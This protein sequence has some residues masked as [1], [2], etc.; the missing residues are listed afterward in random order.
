MVQS[1]EW[2]ER[3]LNYESSTLVRKKFEEF[4]GR[5]LNAGKAQEIAASFAQ[6]RNY[7]TVAQ[8]ADRTVRPLLVYYGVL[9]FSRAIILFRST[10]LRESGLAASHGLSIEGWGHE[11]SRDDAKFEDLAV[12]VGHS[13]TFRELAEATNNISFLRANSSKPNWRLEGDQIPPD[14]KVTI[15]EVASRIP[16]VAA[17][18]TRWLGP[19]R[20]LKFDHSQTTDKRAAL[21]VGPNVSMADVKEIFGE[22]FQLYEELHGYLYVNADPLGF[23]GAISDAV[24][25]MQVGDVVVMPRF[26]SEVMLSKLL[27]AFITSYMLGMLVRYFPSKWGGIL[28]NRRFDESLPT[29]SALLRH[30]EDEYPRLTFEFLEEPVASA[31][32]VGRCD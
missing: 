15:G 5:E 10:K 3:L 27:V 31:N 20:H 11:L 18:V 2:N 7:F 16:E 17:T 14:T 21:R 24:F 9:S 13:G 25:I 6:A 23:T 29:L 1:N 32:P 22:H 30:I 19:L 12:T 28:Y 4:H 26:S 8:T